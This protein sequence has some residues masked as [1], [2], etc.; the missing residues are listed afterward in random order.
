MFETLLCSAFKLETCAFK[1]IAGTVENESKSTISSLGAD[2]K[3]LRKAPLSDDIE[4]QSA[5]LDLRLKLEEERSHAALLQSES[6][7]SQ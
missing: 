1:S 2:L 5:L 6:E 4:A 3:E 7:C